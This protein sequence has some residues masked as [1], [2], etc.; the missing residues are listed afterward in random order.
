MI[1]GRR[2]RLEKRDAEGETTLLFIVRHDEQ[3]RESEA[4]YFT[5]DSDQGTRERFEYSNDGRLQT[6]TYF[7]EPGVASDR[8]ESQRDEARRDVHK[9][10][11]RG[12]GSQY[13]EEDVF[14]DGEDIL[15]VPLGSAGLSR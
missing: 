13:G 6:T 15:A 3:G 1:E 5:A 14:T 11:Y 4:I 9:R 12:D 2:L 10:Y 8:T 7:Y